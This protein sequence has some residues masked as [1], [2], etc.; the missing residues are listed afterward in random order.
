[1]G[2]SEF[3]CEA[4]LEATLT[5]GIEWSAV[6]SW[7]WCSCFLDLWICICGHLACW[8]CEVHGV[9]AFWAFG[10][11]SV[12]TWLALGWGLWCTSSWNLHRKAF[13]K[14]IWNYGGTWES[15]PGPRD[16][17]THGQP[18][19]QTRL[20]VNLINNKYYIIQMRYMLKRTRQFE[21]TTPWLPRPSSSTFP[22]NIKHIAG[23]L[24]PH[25]MQA[26]WK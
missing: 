6:D 11:A 24:N 14:I 23:V 22:V 18:L 12:D 7:A 15:N 9:L 21:L 20:F 3:N 26:L 4:H 10:S 8:M 5:I 25:K 19:N 13:E 1:M 2:G 16:Y 17:K